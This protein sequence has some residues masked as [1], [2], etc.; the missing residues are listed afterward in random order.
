MTA[1]LTEDDVRD[2]IRERIGDRT[3]AKAGVEM[4][5]SAAWLCQILNGSRHPSGKVLD[6]IGVARNGKTPKKALAFTKL[7]E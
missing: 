7:P 2:M 6:I 4:G 5:V 1:I 3:L